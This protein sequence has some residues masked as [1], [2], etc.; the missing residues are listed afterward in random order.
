MRTLI[1]FITALS[2]LFPNE[3]DFSNY[4][5]S[6]IDASINEKTNRMILGTAVVSAAVASQFDKDFQKY[7]QRVGLMPESLARFADDYVM[8]GWSIGLL[9]AGIGADHFL[10]SQSRLDLHWKLQYVFTSIAVSSA[11]TYGF[12]FGVGRE[13]P[14]GD[15]KRS[16]PSGHTSHSFTIAAVS[17]ELFGNKIGIPAYAMAAVVAASRVHDNKHYVS[18]VLFG[19]GIGTIVG[20]GFGT[21]YRNE[22]LQTSFA[23]TVDGQMKLSIRF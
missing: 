5:H 12:K 23:P 16:F 11:I 17:Q 2:L 7:A 3:R 15:N 13:R 6:G 9:S 4:L 19:A 8:K 20:R 10:R 18:D 14:N 1:L 21:V 22:T